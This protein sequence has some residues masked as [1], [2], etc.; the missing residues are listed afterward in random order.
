MKLNRKKKQ[1]RS[2]T[3]PVAASIRYLR[4]YR[5]LQSIS[6][7]RFK[8]RVQTRDDDNP[9][10]DA[11]RATAKRSFSIARNGISE[12]DTDEWKEGIGRGYGAA[13]SGY[14]GVIAQPALSRENHRR[15]GGI[16]R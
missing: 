11:S 16:S 2:T 13:S 7:V 8:S 5:P 14:T 15:R 12:E 9:A 4:R 1:R 6:V 10:C 3:Y